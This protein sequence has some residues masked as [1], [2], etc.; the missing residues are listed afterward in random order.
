MNEKKVKEMMAS[1]S[2]VR[3]N[4]ITLDMARTELLRD[5]EKMRKRAFNMV[6]VFRC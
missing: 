3:D 2:H 1:M 5:Q 6:C 4:I